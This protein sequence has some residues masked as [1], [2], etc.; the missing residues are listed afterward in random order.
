[1][2]IIENIF[3]NKTRRKAKRFEILGG[4]QCL[5]LQIIKVERGDINN[6]NNIQFDKDK[7]C[8]RYKKSVQK[9]LASKLIVTART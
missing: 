1:M 9:I 4:R 2:Q 5:K 3:A 6:T 7:C 8:Y